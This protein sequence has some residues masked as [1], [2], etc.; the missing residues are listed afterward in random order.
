MGPFSVRKW[1]I[2]L[3]EVG[4]GAAVGRA[5]GSRTRTSID[6]FWDDGNFLASLC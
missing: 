5:V 1:I 6:G 4:S 3:V 2:G